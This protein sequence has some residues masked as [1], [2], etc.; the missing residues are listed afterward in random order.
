MQTDQW[1]KWPVLFLCFAFP[2]VM[3]SV[4]DGGST[5]YILLFLLAIVFCWKGW[6]QLDNS[7]KHILFGVLAFVAL[8]VLSLVNTENFNEANYRLEKL[9]RLVMLVPVY[10]LVRRSG[11]DVSRVFLAGVA[12]GAFVL[13]AEAWYQINVDGR[14]FADGAYHKIVFGDT[15]MLLSV[16]LCAAVCTLDLS[17]WQKAGCLLAATAGLYAS[18]LSMTRGAWLLIPVLLPV[19][20]WLYRKKLGRREWAL[21]GGI[22]VLMLGVLVVWQPASI[23]QP[24]MRGISDLQEYKEN[25]ASGT[26]WGVRLNLWHDSL[27]I[28]KQHPLIGT[29]IGDLSVH[30][31]QLA[32]QGLANNVYLEGNHAHSIYFNALA[33]SGILGFGALVAGLFVLPF[34]FF[35][36][37]WNEAQIPVQRFHV[38]GGITTIVAFAVFG[39]SEGWM[40]RNPFV[41]AY[42]MFLIVFMSG[43]AT[44]FRGN[45]EPNGEQ[46][47]PE[48]R[49]V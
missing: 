38:L 33:V 13:A 17:R 5:V 40:A 20:A 35:Y 43:V 45:N 49:V 18:V 46:H 24:L 16:I 32:R 37:R 31:Q 30:R 27:L 28:L 10:L 4:K 8:S 47:E 41:N 7:E 9:F 39:L 3:A 11:V 44:S 25:S 19:W 6:V 14:D 2:V 48:V 36:R 42:A 26:S 22:A 34:R 1:L 29:G 21:A 15:A 23:K 12:V